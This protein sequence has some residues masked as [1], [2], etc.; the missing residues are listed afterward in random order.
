[1]CLND[2]ML[3]PEW[4]NI[5]PNVT[6]AANNELTASIQR[7]QAEFEAIVNCQTDE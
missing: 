1:M 3:I 2:E 4:N 5:K 6:L 7:P